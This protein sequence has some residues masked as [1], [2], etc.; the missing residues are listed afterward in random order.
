MIGHLHIGSTRSLL[1]AT[2]E[3]SRS[4]FDCL[5]RTLTLRAFCYAG[6]ARNLLASFGP[7]PAPAPSSAARPAST[8]VF[9]FTAS[10]VTFANSTTLYVQGVPNVTQWVVFP[11]NPRAGSFSKASTTTHHLCGRV[12]CSKCARQKLLLA[13]VWPLVPRRA[14]WQHM[15]TQRCWYSQ[16]RFFSQALAG[17]NGDW[18]SGPQALLK[19][20]NQ[21]G[22]SSS[23]IMTLHSCAPHPCAC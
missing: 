9:T 15:M 17:A 10:S 22:T 23:V 3:C 11:P 2:R 13:P 12:A 7:A 8:G 14:L 19:G 4:P 18:I 6:N 16:E 5:D 21:N 1:C 20:T